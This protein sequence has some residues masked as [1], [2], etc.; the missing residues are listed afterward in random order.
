MLVRQRTERFRQQFDGGAG[1]GQFPRFRTEQRTVHTNDITNI[2]F[3]KNFK[4]V[5]VNTGLI[6][7]TL[8]TSCPVLQMEENDFPERTGGNNPSCQNKDGVDSFQLFCAVPLKF[9]TN[10]TA[11]VFLFKTVRKQRYAGIPYIA[12]FCHTV[13]YNFVQF[14]VLLKT[15]KHGHKIRNMFRLTCNFYRF[16]MIGGTH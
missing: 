5:F 4:F 3:F 2:K 16:L 10:D 7:I 12:R 11:A 9:S 8:Q 14:P 15:L 1:K 13:F 6:R